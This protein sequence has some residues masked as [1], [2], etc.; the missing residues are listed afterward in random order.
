MNRSTLALA[1]SEQFTPK[2][3]AARLP[4]K[5]DNAYRHRKRRDSAEAV[6]SLSR[7][8]IAEMGISRLK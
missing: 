4:T 5:K 6:M 7:R 8:R 2:G 1:L 3:Q